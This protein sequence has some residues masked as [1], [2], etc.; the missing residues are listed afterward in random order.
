MTIH[1]IVFERHKLLLKGK[2][3]GYSV[4]QEGSIVLKRDGEMGFNIIKSH[5]PESK[6]LKELESFCSS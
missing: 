4:G 6:I 2:L 5:S 1:P 3:L